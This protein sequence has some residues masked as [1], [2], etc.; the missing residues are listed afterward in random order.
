MSGSPL[1]DSDEAGGLFVLLDEALLHEV[2]VHLHFGHLEGAGVVMLRAAKGLIHGA[3]FDVALEA[4][5]EDDE[6]FDIAALAA[7]LDGFVHGLLAHGAEFGADVEVGF[8]L[9]VAFAAVV[10]HR[11]EEGGSQR[12]NVVKD[13]VLP[14]VAG[15]DAGALDQVCGLSAAGIASNSLMFGSCVPS[16]SSAKPS[17]YASYALNQ[18]SSSWSN[19]QS[20]TQKYQTG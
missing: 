7:L 3:V 19:R 12:L 2:V 1:A 4:E 11:I 20:E 13:G 17:Q 14:L 16:T 15:L 6:P 18:W 10:A 9:G 5:S 8:A